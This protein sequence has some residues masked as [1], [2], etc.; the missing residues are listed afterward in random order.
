MSDQRSDDNLPELYSQHL[1]EWERRFAEAFGACGVDGAIIFS[2]AGKRR[3]RDDAE[4]PFFAE[5]Y[6]RAWVPEACAG[7]ALRIV[8]GE[9]PLLLYHESTDYWHMPAATPDGFW[10]RRFLTK[11]TGGIAAGF[12][13]TS[14]TLT[15]LAGN[16]GEQRSIVDDVQGQPTTNQ[17]A[18]PS[19]PRVP[20]SN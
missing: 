15:I 17:P 4:Y 7:S 13:L 20:T 9:T 6:F 2:G 5:P 8:P 3:F 12:M 16:T 1:E 19:G 11:A 10:A 14:L 18:E